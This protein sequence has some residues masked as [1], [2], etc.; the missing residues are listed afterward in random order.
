[1]IAALEAQNVEY[2]LIKGMVLNQYYTP[3]IPRQT[4]DFDFIIK[5]PQQYFDVATYLLRRGYDYVY[6]P[7]FSQYQ[8]TV[9]GISKFKKKVN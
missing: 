6:F 5:E 1:M 9:V 4:N 3:S 8:N 2:I 7:V